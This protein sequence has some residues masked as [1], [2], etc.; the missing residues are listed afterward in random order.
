VERQWNNQEPETPAPAVEGKDQ[1]ELFGVAPGPDDERGEWAP[2]DLEAEE[3]EE[4]D[5]ITS[6]LTSISR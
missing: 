1:E 4:I 2:E 5:T 6:P 3:A